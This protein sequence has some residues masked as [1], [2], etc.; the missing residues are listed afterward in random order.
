MQDFAARRVN[1]DFALV[2]RISRCRA[3]HELATVFT[4]YWRKAAKHYGK[5]ATTLAML[6]I[7][8]TSR[9]V[10]DRPAAKGKQ[11]IVAVPLREAAAV[12]DTL[13]RK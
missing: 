7:N 10:M 13:P 4:E 8:A 11:G 5:E 9:M 12:N 2:R 6:M 1:E 3:P